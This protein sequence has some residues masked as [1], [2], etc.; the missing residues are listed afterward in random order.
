MIRNFGDQ[1]PTLGLDVWIDSSAVVIGAVHLAEGVSIWPTAVLRGDVNYITI[2]QDSNL[3]DGVIVHVN[4]P[5]SKHPEGTPCIVGAGVTVGHRATLHA[6][7][8]GDHVLV[9]M[10]SIVMDEV[11]VESFVII[12]AGSV[13]A[14]GK[15]LESGFLYLGAPA[16]KVRPLTQDERD[17]FTQSAQLYRNLAAQHATRSRT[18]G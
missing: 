1:S 10:G 14:P 8:I 18:V 12:G 6:C 16:R 4:Q 11:V 3:Q 17:Y 7:T 9:G 2:G 15:R 13:V 5:S